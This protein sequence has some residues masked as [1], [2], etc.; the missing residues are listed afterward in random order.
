MTAARL[1][2]W[3]AETH[4]NALINKLVKWTEYLFLPLVKRGGLDSTEASSSLFTPHT[5]KQL[6]STI[7][8]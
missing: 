3:N 2:Q 7:Q 6:K 4:T 8:S 1:F 5:K